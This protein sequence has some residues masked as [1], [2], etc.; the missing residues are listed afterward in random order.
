MSKK[1]FLVIFV[2][3]VCNSFAFANEKPSIQLRVEGTSAYEI[4]SILEAE[5][6]SGFDWTTINNSD[7]VV[8]ITA[9]SGYSSSSGFSGSGN[10]VGGSY[11]NSFVPLFLDIK[12]VGENGRIIPIASN[13]SGR[14]Y[15]YQSSSIRVGNFY[16]NSNPGN[17]L[18]IKNVIEVLR[19]WSP[20][21]K[22]RNSPSYYSGTNNILVPGFKYVSS[23][24]QFKPYQ[25]QI[26]TIWYLKKNNII[27]AVSKI[28]GRDDIK[29]EVILEVVESRIPVENLDSLGSCPKD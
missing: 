15:S 4:K 27:V 22:I 14:Y 5:R 11:N 10:D 23:Y 21:S 16:T 29:K 2:I 1:V 3:F 28:I 13:V 9:R 19:N 6:F 17:T 26:G 25:Y 12:A 7:Y 20:P 24:S 8:T 18:D